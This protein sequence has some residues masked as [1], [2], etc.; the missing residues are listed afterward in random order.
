MYS[1]NHEKL[2]VGSGIAKPKT[3]DQ[4]GVDQDWFLFRTELFWEWEL[5]GLNQGLF[6]FLKT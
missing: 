3:V 6:Q 5:F 4:V 2:H 1:A